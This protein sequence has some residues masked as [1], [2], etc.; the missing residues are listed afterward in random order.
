MT[1][2]TRSLDFMF[3]GI[4][5]SW[6]QWKEPPL[7]PPEDVYLDAH[8]YGKQAETEIRDALIQFSDPDFLD[9]IDWNL[10]DIELSAD[11]RYVYAN[12]LVRVRIPFGALY[13]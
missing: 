6:H 1:A 7:D 10:D 2:S 9:D 3:Q 4:P 5:Q 8:A 13:T 11:Q 12:A